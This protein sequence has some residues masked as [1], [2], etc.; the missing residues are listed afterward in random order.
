[1]NKS[2]SK[3]NEKSRFSKSH[4]LH[5]QKKTTY[6]FTVFKTTHDTDDKA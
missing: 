3:D 1:M 6:N 2:V 5:K 4:Y